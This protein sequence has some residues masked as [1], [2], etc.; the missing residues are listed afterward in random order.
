MLAPHETI[1]HRRSGNIYP[2]TGG[3]FNENTLKWINEKLDLALQNNK[4]VIGMMHHGILEH[5]DKQSKFFEE[6]VV[7][8]SG[9]VSETFAR[10]GLK[11]MFTG[12]YHAQDIV[13]KQFKNGSFIFDI[14][15][16]SLV[17]YPCFPSALC[18]G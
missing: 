1:Q 8:K 5:Y 15:T 10:K 7:E 3:K 18:R 4:T 11:I 12:H 9:K 13:F 2:V 6:Y 14:E 17:T 16:G